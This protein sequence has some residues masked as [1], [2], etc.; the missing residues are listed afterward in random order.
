VNLR[1]DHCRNLPSRTTRELVFKTWV[2]RASASAVA[3][4]TLAGG[5]FMASAMHALPGA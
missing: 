5:A 2:V 3:R 1:K 4:V